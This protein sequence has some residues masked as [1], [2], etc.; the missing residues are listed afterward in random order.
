M[1]K[2][3]RKPIPTT[4]DVKITLNDTHV[5]VEG[6]KGKLSFVLPEGISLS[7]HEGLVVIEK[8]KDTKRQRMFHGLARSLVANMIEGV[9]KGFKKELEIVGVG[10]K[11]Q[12][13]EKLLVLQ[14]GFSHPVEISVEDDLQV[15]TPSAIRITIEGIDKQKVG[16]FAARVR[17]ILPP[18]PYKGKGIRYA[19]EQV[20]K[21]LGK[22]MAKA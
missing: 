1:S 13:K 14:V 3:G 15:T 17:R 4:K 2:I 20:R 18:E 16:E 10:Y 12:M 6:P 8:E 21:K 19:G 7:Q 22:A 11:A 5:L 9:T